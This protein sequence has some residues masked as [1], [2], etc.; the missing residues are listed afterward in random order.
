MFWKLVPNGRS[1]SVCGE[2][3]ERSTGPSVGAPP[4]ATEWQTLRLRPLGGSS[5][6]DIAQLVGVGE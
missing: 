1:C 3:A 6:A 2:S 5:S 4:T